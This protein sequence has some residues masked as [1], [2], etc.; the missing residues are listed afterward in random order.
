MLSYIAVSFVVSRW[1]F[2]ILWTAA[3]PIALVA[4]LLM[5][6]YIATV[7]HLEAKARAD[8]HR[9]IKALLNLKRRRRAFVASM[10]IATAVTGLTQQATS[11]RRRRSWF[12]F[13]GDTAT[14]ALSALSW[15]G[16]D[17]SEDNTDDPTS[18]TQSEGSPR[19]NSPGREGNAGDFRESVTMNE[20]VSRGPHSNTDSPASDES[21]STME[22]LG[23]LSESID[24]YA[25]RAWGAKFERNKDKA[26]LLRKVAVS[27]HP[28]LEDASPLS[29][30]SA[31]HRS[32]FWRRIANC[33]PGCIAFVISSLD[34]TD[35]RT[36][37]GVLVKLEW[38]LRAK[39]MVGDY[40]FEAL[41][42]ETARPT[43]LYSLLAAS[44]GDDSLSNFLAS[45][46]EARR[47]EGTSSETDAEAFKEAG[48]ILL[49][50]MNVT[51]RG[52]S[53]ARVMP[54]DAVKV[55]ETD[56]RNRTIYDTERGALDHLQQ[57][58]DCYRK[59]KDR[60]ESNKEQC[61]VSV[62]TFGGNEEDNCEATHV[63]AKPDIV[64]ATHGSNKGDEHEGVGSDAITDAITC[65]T[66]TIVE[67][68][69]PGEVTAR[70]QEE[71]DSGSRGIT[72]RQT[73]P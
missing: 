65:M 59:M 58:R 54:T 46:I 29:V 70:E 49:A 68:L 48:N 43:M 26:S 73:P 11:P 14:L 64:K 13:V 35:R 28:F 1:R 38:F 27:M 61:A 2:H 33:F 19:S 34:E 62:A 22:A 63:D 55:R 32:T 21:S 67:P 15:Q 7:E 9:R 30:F 23:S 51:R 39:D 60:D 17:A 72:Q 31:D 66:S 18:S 20:H 41:I 56:H 44:Q 53:S 42:E 4:L 25:W 45:C 50:A 3:V 16:E 37:F 57:M 36:M 24:A 69:P 40:A 8:G 6:L 71:T 47:A 10:S 12:S 52:R 5:A